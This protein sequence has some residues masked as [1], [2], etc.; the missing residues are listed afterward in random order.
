MEDSV[1]YPE[2]R[3][4]EPL[5][6]DHADRDSLNRGGRAGDPPREP[7]L[8]NRDPRDV[9]T[10]DLSLPRGR[11][12]EPV[13]VRER[14]YHLRGS[15]SRMLGTVGAFRVVRAEDL[16]DRTARPDPRDADLRHLREEGSS[17][18]SVWRVTA[19]R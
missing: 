6:R 4:P 16:R 7:E 3:D 18:A 13:F 12:R 15:E 14:T 11:D 1:R 19:S 8:R 17:R 2:P 5:D 10:H 9:F